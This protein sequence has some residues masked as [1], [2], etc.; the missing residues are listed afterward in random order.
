MLFRSSPLKAVPALEQAAQALARGDTLEHSIA[1]TGYRATRSSYL[2]MSGDGVATNAAQLIVERADC[3]AIMDPAFTD[4]GVYLDAR[5]LRMVAAAP[6]APSVQMTQNDAGRRVLDLVNR[7]RSQARTCGSKSFGA[8]KPVR[9]NDK[10]AAAGRAHAD[11][12]ARKNYF[13]HDGR[14]GSTPAQRVTRAGYRYRT[15][16]ENIAAGQMDPEGAVAGWIKSPPHCANLMN[17]AFTEMGV[18]F[19][20]ND[21]SEMGVYWAQEFGTPR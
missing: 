20:V 7:A 8:A 15:T 21:K 9:W 12:M 1:A 3:K 5:E 14:D 17:G 18:G 6:F 19:A 13:S 4:V 2:S 10:L 16:G 11:D